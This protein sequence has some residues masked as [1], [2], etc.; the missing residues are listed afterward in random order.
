MTMRYPEW[1]WHNGAIKPWADATTHVMSHAIHYGSSVFEGI[2]S[3]ETPKGPA[4]FRLT[5]HN[6]PPDGLGAHLRHADAVFG[7]RDQRRVPRSVEEERTRARPTC[8]RSRSADSVASACRPIRRPTSRSLHGR[9]ARTSATACSRKASMRAC[10]AGSVSRP[11]RSPRAR[12]P[13][14]II[15]GPVGRARS[16]SPRFRRRHRA[17]VHRP[18]QR[19]RRRKP[20]PRVRRRAAHHADQ[21]RAA[22]RH[23]AQ[24]DHPRSR[25]TTASRWSSA[26]SRANTSTCATSS[27]CAARRRKSR[28]SAR[29][30]AARS[31]SAAPA[32]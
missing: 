12:R 6:A 5:D 19:R 3:Y 17:G 29:S 16:A 14:A 10:R 8:V 4:I 13:A 23:H 9:W 27:S 7:R 1:I 22:Q 15:F 18:A 30:T 32:R 25:A 26:T 20:V 28:R 31:A 11:T 2:R 21:R 24:H